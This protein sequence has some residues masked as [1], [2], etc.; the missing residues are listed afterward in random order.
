MYEAMMYIDVDKQFI[1]KVEATIAHDKR[2]DASFDRMEMEAELFQQFKIINK[3]NK[4]E[5]VPL[6]MDLWQD[7]KV[8][9][10]RTRP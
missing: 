6:I 2:K 10:K 8:L 9:E 3:I 1:E 4:A 5:N 7:F